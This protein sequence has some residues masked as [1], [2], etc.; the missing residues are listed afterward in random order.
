MTFWLYSYI[1]IGAVFAAF[2]GV[3]CSISMLGI[4]QQSGYSGFVFT[5]WFFRRRNMLSRRYALLALAMLLSV[6]LFNFTFSFLGAEWANLISA[7]PFFGFGAFFYFA[8]KRA[9]KVPVK[10][11]GRIIRLTACYFVLTFAL[12]FGAS[13][14][15]SFAAIAIGTDLAYLLRYVPVTLL[16]LFYP[17]LL[18]CA[19]FFTKAYEVPRN[20]RFIKKAQRTLEQS[21]C[22]KVGI[23]G[24][25]AKTSV[26]R[27]AETILSEKFRVIATP[28]SYNTPIGIARTVNESGADCDIFLAEMGARRTGDIKE[29]C[30]MVKPDFGIITG[31]CPQHLETFGTLE[32]I[33]REKATLASYA[34]KGCVLGESAAE[35]AEGFAAGKDFETFDVVCTEH[36][37]EF[38]LRLGGETL[39]LSTPLLGRHAAEDISLACALCSLL[40]MSAEE[41]KAG[42]AKIRPVPHRLQKIEGNGLN[43]LDDSYNS[44][45][46]GAKDAVYALRLFGGKRY[47]VTPGLVELG[48]IEEAANAALGELFAGLDGVILVGETL[49]LAVREGYLQ[50]GGDAA[51][52]RVVP[53][54]SE[55]QKILA[56]E[57]TAG[58]SVLFL[59]DLPDIYN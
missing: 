8:S 32:A 26:K 28:A 9:L 1:A 56:R 11:T 50:A 49:V 46:E 16:P 36:G 6:A 21:A 40:G 34:K 31:V 45:V 7:V 52:L 35:L 12:V 42:V 10:R 2:V 15:F 51:K 44:N 38:T 29:L 33:K 58:D 39:S 13:V 18:V 25:F 20:R 5:R 53:T 59:N 37:T 4:M 54:L 14:G 48:Q 30:E 47:V 24:S 57:L 43:I 3:L 19:N 27:F 22:V 23:T 41:I 55:A 17:L